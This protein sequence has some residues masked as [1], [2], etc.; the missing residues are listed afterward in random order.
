M[1]EFQFRSDDLP[2]ADRFDAFR[3]LFRVYAPMELSSRHA[4]A[5]H[6][7][8]RIWRL[9]EVRAWSSAF[10][11]TVFRRT[12]RL[13]RRSDP[14]VYHLSFPVSGQATLTRDGRDVAPRPREFFTSDSSRPCAV[15]TEHDAGLVR[16]VAVDIP[17]TSLSLPRSLADR[18]IG[19]SLPGATGIGALLVGLLTRL[20]SDADGFGPSDGPR[21]GPVVADLVS[22]LF[23][24]ELETERCL[25]PE[26]HRRTLLLR[27]WAFIGQHVRDP[28][29]TPATIAAAHHISVSFLHRLFQDHD[30]TVA[31]AIRRLRLEGARRE[32]ADPA[33]ATVPIHGIAARWG[34]ENPVV[35]TRSFRAMFGQTPS[36]HRH[37]ASGAERRTEH[38]SPRGGGPAT[39]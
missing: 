15:A 13:I 5:F 28:D 11:P 17:K 35:F 25:P 1:R 21:L 37:G 19:R 8:V 32:L 39:V 29:L 7:E 14:E 34:Y 12:R 20:A 26:S 3:D 38:R 27:V 2:V 23:A 6:G 22:A 36:D 30:T 24:H 31:A 10:R 16:S 33:L 18:M 9:G 4:A